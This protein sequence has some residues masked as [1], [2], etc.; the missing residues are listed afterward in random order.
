MGCGLIMVWRFCE[1]LLLVDRPRLHKVICNIWMQFAAIESVIHITL[2]IFWQRERS[3]T[4]R[5]FVL[6][7]VQLAPRLENVF[8]SFLPLHWCQS[9]TGSKHYLDIVRDVFAHAYQNPKVCKGTNS[10]QNPEEWWSPKIFRTLQWRGRG[11]KVHP[12]AQYSVWKVVWKGPELWPHEESSHLRATKFS[13]KAATESKTSS[14]QFVL[15]LCLWPTKVFMKR[16]WNSRWK[17]LSP[18]DKVAKRY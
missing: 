4:Y 17:S 16:L 11:Q 18:I 1:G 5:F 7:V 13:R 3:I 15:A 12:K 6:E 10:L 8:P 9:T 14:N 2:Y